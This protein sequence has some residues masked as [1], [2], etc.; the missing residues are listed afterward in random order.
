MNIFRQWFNIMILIPHLHWIIRQILIK[1]WQFFSW[2]K[3]PTSLTTYRSPCILACIKIIFISISSKWPFRSFRFLF[4]D[5]ITWFYHVLFIWPSILLNFTVYF[6]KWFLKSWDM[7]W[8]IL[9]SC[10]VNTSL[11]MMTLFFFELLLLVVSG[12]PCSH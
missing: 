11:I 10:L 5:Q 7:I 8:I 9:Y 2:S 1:V 4:R 3:C 12:I 6:V